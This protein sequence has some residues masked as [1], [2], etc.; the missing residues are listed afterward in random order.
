M[1]TETHIVILGG[2]YAGSGVA[3]RVLKAVPTAKVT[4]INATPYYYFNLA[5]PRFLAKPA[6]VP[7]EKVLLS[8]ADAFKQY[9]ASRFAFV[10]GLVTSIDAATKTVHLKDAAAPVSYDYLVIATGS[11]TPGTI[12]EEAIPFKAPQSGDFKK[13]IEDAQ[14]RIASAQ[15]IIIGGAGPVGVETAAEIAQAYPKKKVTLI[16]SHAQV[17]P[18]LNAKAANSATN[19]L[20]KLGVEIKL[21]TMVSSATVQNGKWTVALQDGSKLETELYISAAGTIPNTSF[22]PAAYLDA[23]KGVVVDDNLHVAAITDGSVF[24]VGDVTSFKFRY[25]LKALPQILVVVANL[26]VAISGKGKMLVHKEDTSIMTLVPT[27]NNSGTGMIAGFALPNFF[28]TFV[29]GKDF[30]IPKAADYL[31]GKA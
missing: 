21:S 15:S 16:S 20:R 23:D 22:L 28:V 5:S 6:E 10:E 27:G 8:I 4:I 14:Q 25:L 30:F 3:Q 1:S 2:N 31:T 24:A 7:L 17:L 9:P 26:K 11:T 13:I 12:G 29:K 18:I 19:N